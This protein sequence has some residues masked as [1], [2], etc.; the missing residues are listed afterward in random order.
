MEGGLNLR[1]LLRVPV[2]WVEG[3]HELYSGGLR[4]FVR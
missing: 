3:L 2:R 1:K 4:A